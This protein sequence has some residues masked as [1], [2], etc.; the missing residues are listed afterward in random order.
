VLRCFCLGNL[1]YSPRHL[2]SS[3]FDWTLESNSNCMPRVIIYKINPRRDTMIR[4][5]SW[6]SPNELSQRN[7]VKK[8]LN[9]S[10]HHVLT[11]LRSSVIPSSD[12]ARDDKLL[13]LNHKYK[14]MGVRKNTMSAQLHKSIILLCL[15]FKNVHIRT[16]IK[17]TTNIC[18]AMATRLGRPR[19]TTD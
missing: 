9:H 1:T 4:K 10:S 6:A 16:N 19:T 7:C 3:L 11:M 13:W 15:L 2:G 14:L 8:I 17:L 12:T 18:K 5:H